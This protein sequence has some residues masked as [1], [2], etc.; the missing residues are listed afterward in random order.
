MRISAGWWSTS[1]PAFWRPAVFR[2]SLPEQE[3][4]SVEQ[5][6][7]DLESAGVDARYIPEVDAIVPVVA[8]E[9][10]EGD[11][12]VVMSNGGFENIH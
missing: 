2:S 11:V 4:L 7:G 9:A 1:R 10:D 8:R 5:L 3:R 6:V 12:V